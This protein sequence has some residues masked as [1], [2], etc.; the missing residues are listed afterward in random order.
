MEKFVVQLLNGMEVNLEGFSFTPTYAGLIV[1][2]PNDE[3][4]KEIIARFDYP[5]NWG[6]HKA[7]IRTNDMYVSKNILKPFQFCAFLS[8]Y[9][10]VKGEKDYDGSSIII[11]WFGDFPKKDIKSILIE[12]IGNFDWEKY[13]ENFKI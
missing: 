13:A 4:N 7:L 2:E 9:E 6:Q 3:I 5:N 10:P 1:G 8:V 11:S 12:K